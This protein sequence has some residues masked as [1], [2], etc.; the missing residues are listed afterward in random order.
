MATQYQGP[1]YD[2]LK[3]AARTIADPVAARARESIPVSDRQASRWYTPG[4]MVPKVSLTRTGAG[5]RMGTPSFPYAPWNEFGGNRHA[6]HE[7]HRYFLA[8]GRYLYPAAY[9]LAPGLA[10]KYAAAL[11]KVL[12]DSSLWTN[13]TDNPEGVHD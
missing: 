8:R 12:N 10:P 9:A 13:S 5:V 3:A 4:K 2:A 1:V 7:S 11:G 6:P